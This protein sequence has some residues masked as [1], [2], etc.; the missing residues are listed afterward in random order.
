MAVTALSLQKRLLANP[1]ISAPNSKQL[2]AVGN[3]VRVPNDAAPLAGL[4]QIHDAALAATLGCR[5]V[6]ASGAEMSAAA[7]R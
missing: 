7:L 4:M 6:R 1:R 2:K 3:E 5:Y